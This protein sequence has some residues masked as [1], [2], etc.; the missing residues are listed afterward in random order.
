[1]SDSDLGFVACTAFSSHQAHPPQVKGAQHNILC[2]REITFT[3]FLHY[4]IYTPPSHRPPTT[5]DYAISGSNAEHRQV[6]RLT[7]EVRRGANVLKKW[8][9]GL[10]GFWNLQRVTNG[11]Q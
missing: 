8:V 11:G 7:S 5:Q 6:P 10:P 9:L 2:D 1:M 3:T 4:F